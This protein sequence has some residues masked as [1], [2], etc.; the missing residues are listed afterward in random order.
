MF[1]G[2]KA[3]YQKPTQ[4]HRPVVW[5][6]ILGTVYARSP[7]GKI[8]YFDYNWEATMDFAQLDREGADPRIWKTP[9]RVNINEEHCLYA[10]QRAIWSK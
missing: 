8:E 1:A 2:F 10:G 4:K 6:G 3:P 7:E 5:E 9:E